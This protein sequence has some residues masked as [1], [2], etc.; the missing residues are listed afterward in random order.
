MVNVAEDSRYWPY[1]LTLEEVAGLLGVTPRAVRRRVAEKRMTPPPLGTRLRWHRDDVVAYLSDPGQFVADWG[2]KRRVAERAEPT[3]L[4]TGRVREPVT[5]IAQLPVILKIG[6]MAA[7][8]RVSTQSIRR[9]VL[10][11]EMLPPPI[12][13]RPYRWSRFDL[14][15]YFKDMHQIEWSLREQRSRE[16]NRAERE[17]RHLEGDPALAY[18][19]LESAVEL[20][21]TTDGALHQRVQVAIDNDVSRIRDKDLPLTLLRSWKGL[22]PAADVAPETAPKIASDI[23]ALSSKLRWW[24]QADKPGALW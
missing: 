15:R 20:L 12:A 2:R 9:Q 23:V 16:R 17:R 11:F 19:R 10:A 6:D 14:E 22:P 21:A 13:S 5:D 18:R 24:L 7:T 8:L 4:Q 3:L 1:V